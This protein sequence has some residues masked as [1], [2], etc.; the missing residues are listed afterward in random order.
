VQERPAPATGTD[1]ELLSALS[2]CP[3][4]TWAAHTDALGAQFDRAL[5]AAVKELEPKARRVSL[6]GATIR[7]PADL[8]AW[9]AQARTTIETN[10]KD[11]PVIL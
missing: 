4:A 10:L 7:T 5:S 1:D 6:S 8:D 9:L 11:G 2:V 3:L